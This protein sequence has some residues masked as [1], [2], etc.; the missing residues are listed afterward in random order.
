MEILSSAPDPSAAIKQI[1]PT[2][3]KPVVVDTPA[4]APAPT[5][6]APPS[7]DQV[8]ISAEAQS[9]ANATQQAPNAP[10]PAAQAAETTETAPS[11]P[12]SGSANNNASAAIEAFQNVASQPEQNAVDALA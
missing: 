1:L 12:E 11:D 8:S 2:E 3:S 6:I 9:L 5:P 4:S 10:A 7:I